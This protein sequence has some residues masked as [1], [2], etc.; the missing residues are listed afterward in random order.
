MVTDATF[1]E[2]VVVGGPQKAWPMRK[3]PVCPGARLQARCSVGIGG[4][5]AEVAPMTRSS[6]MR[7]PV[8]VTTVTVA[9]PESRQ[10]VLPMFV[11]RTTLMPPGPTYWAALTLRSWHV[12]NGAGASAVVVV[13]VD[14]V[15]G[16]G[17]GTHATTPVVVR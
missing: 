10:V 4:F 5:G 6:W 2:D 1:V 15:G 7:L 12:Q 11:M 17:V 16:A 8:P 9:K 3:P 13:V 14:V